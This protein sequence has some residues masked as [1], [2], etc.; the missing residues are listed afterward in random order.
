MY[1]QYISSISLA[2]DTAVLFLKLS[3][4][5]P[6]EVLRGSEPLTFPHKLTRVLISGSDYDLPL[7]AP[8][9]TLVMEPLSDI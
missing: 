7:M 2:F 6:R 4:I 5:L 8:I 1:T 3:I 9:I